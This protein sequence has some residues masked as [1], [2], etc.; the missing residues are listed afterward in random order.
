M[1][2]EKSLDYWEFIN[3]GGLNII[4]ESYQQDPYVNPFRVIYFNQ[5]SSDNAITQLKFSFF[6]DSDDCSFIDSYY[7]ENRLEDLDKDLPISCEEFNGIKYVT[8]D[9]S[10][11]ISKKFFEDAGLN[12]FE[13]DSLIEKLYSFHFY[14]Q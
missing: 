9:T 12:V 4:V 6:S 10:Y 7:K 13:V 14:K 5:D 8:S 1:V 2:I 11:D 3:K